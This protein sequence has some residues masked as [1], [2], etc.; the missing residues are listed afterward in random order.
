MGDG[1]KK[2]VSG[3]KVTLAELLGVSGKSV[4]WGRAL[5]FWGAVLL[6]NLIYYLREFIVKTQP[7]SP[8]VSLQI[9]LI[10]LVFI[11][12]I[13]TLSAFACFRMIRHEYGAAAITGLCY[14]L[15][16]QLVRLPFA[17]WLYLDFNLFYDW[18]WVF[19]FLFTLSLALRHCQQLLLALLLGGMLGGLA[20]QIITNILQFFMERDFHLVLSSELVSMLLFFLNAIFFALLLWAGLHLP[21]GQWQKLGSEQT[22]YPIEP[23]PSASADGQL[24]KALDYKSLQ[25]HLRSAGIGS[26]L[27]G[28]I[29]IFFGGTAMKGAPVNLVLVLLGVVL[30]LEGIWA[31]LRPSAV[32]IIVDGFVL[33]ALGA[34]NIFV[35]VY[36][37]SQTTSSGSGAFAVLG[38]W[39]VVWGIQSF[40]Q[41]DRFAYLSC[42][43]VSAAELKSADEKIAAIGNADLLSSPDLIE[44]KVKT[45]F[46]EIIWRGKLLPGSL[47]LIRGENIFQVVEKKD[48]DI[49]VGEGKPQEDP[50][51]GRLRLAKQT[52][53]IRISR[54]SLRRFQEWKNT[55]NQPA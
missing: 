16:M 18:L 9:H 14:L 45:M 15:L 4:I 1:M 22:K 7:Y 24:R 11:P 20:T 17:G 29:A 6:S 25:N 8:E 42:Q 21:W 52:T 3:M 36:N 37:I 27:F 33:I 31:L 50:L 2:T 55:A 32:G 46:K 51:P 35:T 49:T 40:R 44:Y 30:L 19:L 41:Y 48:S 10:R 5:I 53:A 12:L 34:W 13:L 47:L 26:I 38:A 28:I 39:Q 43:T 54:E 23:V